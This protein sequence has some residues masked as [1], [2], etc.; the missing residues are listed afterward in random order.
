[1]FTPIQLQYTSITHIICVEVVYVRRF[2]A[3]SNNSF[4]WGNNNEKI[5]SENEDV[6]GFMI[7]RDTS[8]FINGNVWAAGWALIV[9]IFKDANIRSYYMY[10]TE[11]YLLKD[12]YIRRAWIYHQSAMALYIII[13][14]AW[15][16]LNIFVSIEGA[17]QSVYIDDWLCYFCGQC[18]WKFHKSSFVMYFFFMESREKVSCRR[19]FD[20]TQ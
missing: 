8:M 1:M 20:T 12:R 7:L 10:Y 6:I 11:Y 18:W 3:M 9:F 16:T 19:I 2:Y 4:T 14:V 13:K 17:E 15:K 5:I